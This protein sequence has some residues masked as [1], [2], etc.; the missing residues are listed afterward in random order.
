MVQD[1]QQPGV[2]VNAQQ[3]M[4]RHKTEAAEAAI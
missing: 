2:N 4:T 1:G 3:A